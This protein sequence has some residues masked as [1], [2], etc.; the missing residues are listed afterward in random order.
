MKWGNKLCLLR[1]NVSATT[2][3][4]PN[5]ASPWIWTLKTS[6]P[7]LLSL[8]GKDSVYGPTPSSMLSARATP[9]PTG[10]TASK[11]DGLGNTWTLTGLPLG[12][13]RDRRAA[14]VVRC[15][16][17]SPVYAGVSRSSVSEISA[18]PLSWTI[19]YCNTSS[20]S[21]NV[22]RWYGGVEQAGS[23]KMRW[24]PHLLE[25]DIEVQW[26]QLS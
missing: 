3:C 19:G 15:E 22:K 13:L 16:R 18:L 2:P 5:A 10:E 9:R 14:E 23:V 1:F 4:P 21:Q 24:S 8:T 25:Q 11:C 7:I 17:T 26:Q 12:Q 6:S 20:Y